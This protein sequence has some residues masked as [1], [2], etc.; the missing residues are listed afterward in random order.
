MLDQET[1][2]RSAGSFYISIVK[3]PIIITS[4]QGRYFAQ[5]VMNILQAV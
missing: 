4:L 2:D 3:A 1:V 5:I